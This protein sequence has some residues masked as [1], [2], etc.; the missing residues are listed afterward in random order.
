MPGWPWSVFLLNAERAFQAITCQGEPRRQPMKNIFEQGLARNEANF[1]PISPLSFIERAAEVYPQRLAV[2]HGPLRRSWSEVYERCRRLAGALSLRDIGKGDTVAVMLPNT[3]AMVEAHFGIPMAGAVL[4]ALNTRLDA[5]TIA[6]MLDHGEARA[7]LVD[8]EF[9]GVID[10]ALALRKA[11]SPI[12]VVDV[13]DAVFSGR[14]DRIGSIT[15]EEL[16]SE[17]DP[18]FSWSLPGD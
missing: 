10:K 4:N 14:V 7:I 6:F 17:G 18:V 12:L 5:E 15:Y 16:L 1:A 9:T 2:I 11:K 3:P 13:E 8:P